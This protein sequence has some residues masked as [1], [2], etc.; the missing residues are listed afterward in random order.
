MVERYTGPF[1][2]QDTTYEDDITALVFIN[3]EDNQE[4]TV[5][6]GGYFADDNVL[7][8]KPGT[9][10]TAVI[11]FYEGITPLSNDTDNLPV[12]MRPYT[13]SFVDYCTAQAAYLDN[14]LEAGDRFMGFANADMNKFIK[15]IGP[16]H[17]TGTKFITL[18]SP[19]DGQG[20][21][22]YYWE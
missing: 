4:Y 8:M 6:G 16:R 5:W 1:D 19:I 18:D 3:P 14:D 13:K 10:G 11:H 17:K 12:V 7:G 2:G 21:S 22:G 15:E 20:N 9:A